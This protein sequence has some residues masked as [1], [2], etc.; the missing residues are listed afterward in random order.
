MNTNK[1]FTAKEIYNRLSMSH[2]KKMRGVPMRNIIEWCSTVEIEYIEDFP[3]FTEIIGHELNVSDYRAKM[4]CNVFKLE[5][6]YTEGNKRLYN[7][8]YNG[9]Y[10]FFE[11]ENIQT[12]KILIDF[13][14]IPLDEEGF[15][16]LLV[17]HEEAC[18]KYCIYQL[19]QEDFA[20][21]K[22]SSFFIQS[23][24]AEFNDAVDSARSS[25][26]HITTDDRHRFL[27]A[28]ANIIPNVNR[29]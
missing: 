15:P 4:P 9:S 21:G 23:I 6:V 13:R 2:K 3:G 18:T 19:Y 20:E 16:L 22:V 28:L 8:G 24:Q 11:R 14:G 1:Y 7:Y 17:G 27:M 10:L 25:H 29:I 12:G 5:N 26:R